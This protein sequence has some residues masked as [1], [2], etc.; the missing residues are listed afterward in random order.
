MPLT[1]TSTALPG[2]TI[3]DPKVF[4]DDRGFF[5]ETYKKSEFVGAGLD[6]EFVQE[7]HSRSVYGTLRGLHLQREPKAQAKLIRVIDGTIF[8]VVA[9]VRRGSPSFGQ[10]LSVILSAD[11]RRSLF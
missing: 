6:L 5:M 4:T 8:D 1:F 3:I 7:N 2:V 10:W 9:D 11:N